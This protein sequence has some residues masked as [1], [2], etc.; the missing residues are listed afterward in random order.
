MWARIYTALGNPGISLIVFFLSSPEV[1]VLIFLGKSLNLRS[2]VKILNF[3]ILKIISDTHSFFQEYI[4]S[5]WEKYTYVLILWTITW[6]S[7]PP[8]KIVSFLLSIAKQKMLLT[9]DVFIATGLFSPLKADCTSHKR[10]LRSSPP[11]NSGKLKN[12]S[13]YF[14]RFFFWD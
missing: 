11:E 7:L 8:E 12:M 14:G 1:K 10:T 2:Y 4:A 9:C 3:R 6:S 13:Q 5:K